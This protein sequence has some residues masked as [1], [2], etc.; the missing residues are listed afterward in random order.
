MYIVFICRARRTFA[1][2]VRRGRRLESARRAFL[3]RDGAAH[4][5]QALFAG[6]KVY[7]HLLSLLR[8]RSGVIAYCIKNATE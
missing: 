1:S 4:L 8:G 3:P 2:P 7:D 6:P 5:A